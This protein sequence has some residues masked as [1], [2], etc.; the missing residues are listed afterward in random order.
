MDGVDYGEEKML[1][2]VIEWLSSHA[3]DYVVQDNY[4]GKPQLKIKSEMFDELKQSM[5]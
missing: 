2:R 5:Q 3:N 4:K 1:E